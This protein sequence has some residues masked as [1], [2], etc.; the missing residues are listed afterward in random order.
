MSCFCQNCGELR[1]ECDKV[2]SKCG[3]S[4]KRFEIICC[5]NLELH[6]QI[7]GK[8]SNFITNKIS[9]IF[10]IGDNFFNKTKRWHVLERLI[11]RKNNLYKEYIKDEH[12]NIIKNVIEPLSDHT[13]HGSAKKKE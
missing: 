3:C 8:I 6:D 13:G 12:G 7:N 5:D 11:D 2:C 1:S 9:V 4:K 10:K